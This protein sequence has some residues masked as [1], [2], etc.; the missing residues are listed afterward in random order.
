ME[1]KT[2]SKCKEVKNFSDFSK[3]KATKDGLDY[4]CKLC[5]RAERLEYYKKNKEILNNAQKKYYERNKDKVKDYQLNYRKENKDKVKDDFKK[6]RKKNKL[7][8]N[9]RARI[10]QALK[11]GNYKKN[12]NTMNIIGVSIEVAKAHLERQFTKGMSW[13]NH[14]EWHIDHIIPLA[15]A[16]TEEEIIK[17]CHYTNLQPLWAKDNLEKSYKIIETQMKLTI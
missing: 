14:G 4:G 10:Y 2:C 1:V 5:Q 7:K 9:L 13:S 3:R 16:N 15:S 12:N 11:R 17:L 6:W 8:C